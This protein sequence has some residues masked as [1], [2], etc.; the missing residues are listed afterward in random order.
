MQLVQHRGVGKSLLMGPL[1]AIAGYM[2]LALTSTLV[3]EVWLGGVSYRDSGRL[4]L[5]LAGAFTPLCAFAGGLVGALVAGR[6]R[7]LTAAILCGLIIVETTYLSI[8]Q[9]VD[10]PLW[11]EAGAAAALILAVC[12]ATWLS[13]HYVARRSTGF[14]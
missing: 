5:I 11:F 12:A 1:G 7:W 4:V 9:R 14:R 6:S 3:Q 13:G 8:T 10:G 2:T